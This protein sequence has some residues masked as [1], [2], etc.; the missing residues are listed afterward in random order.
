[1]SVFSLALEDLRPFSA[2]FTDQKK[3]GDCKGLS[4]YMKAALNAVGIKSNIAMINAGYN[5]LPVDP[6]FPADE[7]DHVILMRA[8]EK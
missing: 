5:S 7:F 6:M 8:S 3:Y 4:N 1:M 2:N